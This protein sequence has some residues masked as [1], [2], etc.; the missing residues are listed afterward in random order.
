MVLNFYG[1][2]FPK[3]WAMF[4][5]A[6]G[7]VFYCCPWIVP[8]VRGLSVGY[9]CY[10]WVAPIGFTHGCVLVTALRFVLG[11]IKIMRSCPC[12]H[13]PAISYSLYLTQHAH[14]P[15]AVIGCP[16][17]LDP[18]GHGCFFLLSLRVI[19][20]HCCWIICRDQF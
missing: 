10:P 15:T 7:N 13:R 6:M 14:V 12:G 8:V 17:G 19:L 3:R 1:Q 5:H 11:C 16:A 2:R 18:A 4:F 20:R 9:A